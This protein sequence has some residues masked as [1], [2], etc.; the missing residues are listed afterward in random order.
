MGAPSAEDF[1][2][3]TPLFHGHINPYGQFTLDLRG[4]R[5][6]RSRDGPSDHPQADGQEA[7]PDPPARAAGLCVSQEGLS[8]H[9]EL[10]AVRRQGR[11]RLPQLLTDR[12]LVA[13]YEAVWQARD[14]KH[15]VL[16]KV[17]IFTGLR[18]SEL[19]Q[20]QA[21]G[22]GPGPVPDPRGAGQ[23]RQ[24][25][26][27]VVPDQF[28][29]R[30]AQYIQGR[31][32]AVAVYLFESNRLRPYSTDASARSSMS[33]PRPR[34]LEAGLSPPVPA[35]DHHVP[36]QEGHHQPQAATAQR[37]C[38]GEEPG[39]LSRSGPGRRLGRV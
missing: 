11:K 25:P 9:A 22:R 14:P 8:A 5:S 38:R 23:G 27:R 1:R 30:V 4:L 28:P 36:H 19:A 7:G 20:V 12:E 17:L 24:G 34:G 35:P 33:T 37:P 21:A 31:R 16:I 26:E 2:A 6:W 15:M 3:L 32:I 10:L 13:F 39:H 29:R 18:N